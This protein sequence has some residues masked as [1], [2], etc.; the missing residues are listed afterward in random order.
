MA[1]IELAMLA[2]QCLDG[3]LADRATLER[4]LAAW[5]APR[6]RAGRGVNSGMNG[7]RITDPTLVSDPDDVQPGR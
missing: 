2:Q 1:E 6:N 5:Q 3:R 7:A 4:E